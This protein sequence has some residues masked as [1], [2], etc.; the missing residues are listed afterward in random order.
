MQKM[1]DAEAML[2]D[3]KKRYAKL[4][5]YERGFIDGLLELNDIGDMSYKQYEKLEQIWERIT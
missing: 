3:C 5:D 2:Q 4:Y 1:S